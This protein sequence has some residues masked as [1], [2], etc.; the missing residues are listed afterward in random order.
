MPE[1]IDPN[2]GRAAAPT[3]PVQTSARG[4]DGL[5]LHGAIFDGKQPLV[6]R[7]VASLLLVARPFV[8][9][10]FLLLV[11]MPGAPSC[12]LVPSSDERCAQKYRDDMTLDDLSL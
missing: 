8:S 9:S 7:P 6:V 2:V 12:V 10:S 1:A 3:C 5:P 11:A 4:A